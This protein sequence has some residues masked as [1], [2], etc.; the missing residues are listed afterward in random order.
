MHFF[1]TKTMK[2]DD[3]GEETF[4]DRAE[5]AGLADKAEKEAGKTEEESE[6]REV[7][8]KTWHLALLTLVSRVLGLFREMTKAW[9]LGTGWL[10]DAFSSAFVLPNFV[11][12]LFAEGAISTGFIPGFKR[13]LAEKA[14]KNAGQF[15]SSSLTLLGIV[16]LAAT[17]LGYVF[18]PALAG[19]FGTD[20]AETTLL[21]RI[22]FP[23][24][25]TTAVAALFQGVLNTL[26]NFWPSALASIL[27]NL[28]AIAIPWA[29][30]GWLD[31]PARRM[32]VGV[33]IGGVA[34]ILC[35]LP[36]LRKTGLDIRLVSPRRAFGDKGAVEAFKAMLPTILGMAAYHLNDIIGTIFAARVG[37]GTASSLQYSLRLQEFILGIFAVS[38]GTVLLPTLVDRARRASWPAFSSL[39]GRALRDI[40]FVSIP[41]AAFSILV[42]EQLVS[43][44]FQGGSFTGQSARLTSSIFVWHQAGLV[45]IAADKILLPVFLALGDTKTPAL[46]GLASFLVN[47]LLAAVLHGRF[48]GQGIAFSLSFAAFVNMVALLFR[49]RAAPV[50]GLHSELSAS[51]HWALRLLGYS[52]VAAVPVWFLKTP[53]LALFS[54]NSSRLLSLGLPLVI[55]GT[56]FAGV[57]VGLIVAVKDPEGETVAATYKAKFKRKMAS[58]EH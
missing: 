3:E 10:S 42:S 36:S 41:T 33:L 25:T 38:A 12:R 20:R 34:Q 58:G 7:A 1:Q 32:A 5:G 14:T 15:A 28:I 35:Q 48:G 57:G 8:R 24:L 11:R 56:V 22:M 52:L 2:N 29:F 30:P 18:A 4:L 39:F 46:A 16:G 19:L 26:G 27:F 54:S 55:L 47:L 49:L 23:F 43:L 45:F 50:P 53:L 21:L 40:L 51:F 9:F 17:L 6:E 37:T 13:C 44:L 31:N